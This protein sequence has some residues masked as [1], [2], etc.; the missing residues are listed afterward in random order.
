MARIIIARVLRIVQQQLEVLQQDPE[1]NRSMEEIA[2]ELG[3]GVVKI[4]LIKNTNF[5]KLAFF[6]G[7]IW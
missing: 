6:M 2:V 4:L 5:Y 1:N 3:G 7:L